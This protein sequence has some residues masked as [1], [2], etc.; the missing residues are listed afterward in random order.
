MVS[1]PTK[2]EMIRITNRKNS[3]VGDYYIQYHPIKVVTYAKYLGLI[4]D[5]CLSFNEHINRI[6][7]K[8][9]SVN[10]FLQR[11][12]KSCPPK[13]NRDLLQDS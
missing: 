9:N 2:C 1:N 13:V 4:I 8:A 10:A 3:I 11:N 12:I 6:S 5:D 7:L